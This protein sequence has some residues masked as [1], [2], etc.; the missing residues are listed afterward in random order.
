MSR[1]NGSTHYQPSGARSCDIGGAIALCVIED[2]RVN[3]SGYS[4]FPHIQV[5]D[6]TAGGFT[7]T[8]SVFRNERLD[9]P[10]TISRAEAFA[11]ANAFR[12]GNGFDQSLMDRVQDALSRT[13]G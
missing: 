10:F 9:Y 12:S 1:I 13:T 4:G 2:L 7:V 5:T 11:A 3:Y 6:D 8:I